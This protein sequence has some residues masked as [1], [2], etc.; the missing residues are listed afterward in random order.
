M[1]NI[2]FTNK[3]LSFDLID[4]S[5]AILVG[6]NKCSDTLLLSSLDKPLYEEVCNILKCEGDAFNNFSYTKVISLLTSSGKV[7]YLILVGAG[8]ISN[9][10]SASIE[11]LG[12]K[13][14]MSAK[15][16]GIQH[17][18]VSTLYHFNNFNSYT[19]STLIASGILLASYEF[20]K[21]KTAI[22]EKKIQ[23]VEVFSENISKSEKL[24]LEKKA[25][26]SGVFFA[27]D[28]INEPPNVL[29]PLSYAQRIIE[30]FK[31]LNVNVSVLNK[32]EMKSLGMNAM[33]AVG[34][35]SRNEPQLVVIKYLGLKE[36]RGFITM[37]G[38]GVTFDSGGISLKPSN[39]MSDMKYDM[40]G[41]ATIAGLIRTLALRKAR[42]NVLGILALV[43]N[44]P[45]GSAQR[46]GDIVTTMSGKTVEVLNT[47]AEGRLIL[48]DAIWFAQERFSSKHIIDLATL[49]GAIVVALGNVYAGL[50][51]N[52][53][54]L[55]N[56]LLNAASKVKENLW[57]MPLDS[58]FEE[59]LKSDIADIAN[60]AY[61][62]GSA[63]SSV[64]AQFL[65]NFIKDDTSW[66]HLDIAGVAWEKNGSNICPKGAVGF[67]VRLLN[68]LIQDYYE[69][70]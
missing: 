20:N 29:Y 64:A 4:Q 47:D 37:V 67:G 6:E 48:A 68:Q 11:E 40:A 62:G 30:L 63:G 21:Y 65:K 24:F 57:K 55:A 25:I 19:I 23:L 39:N 33:L 18:S 36:D 51:S 12:G 34:Q 8:S 1:L 56:N 54:N 46:P 3:N 69:E 15:A 7:N 31:E 13:I 27:R 9:L 10:S 45:G 44:M 26:A 16:L 49:T 2:I 22:K 58:K 70:L 60:I 52:D 53:N 61:S 38:K 32:E 5:F 42:V 43:E 66:A 35:G 14:F 50:F 41:S 59:M 28:C 17:L